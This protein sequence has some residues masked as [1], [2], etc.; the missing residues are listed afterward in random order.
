MSQLK[1]VDRMYLEGLFEMRGGYVLSF[2]NAT[3]ADFVRG[4]TG[5]DIYSE[6]YSGNGGSKANRQAAS[7]LEQRTGRDGRG[8]A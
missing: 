4:S 2:T 8:S 1:P 6:A 5:E 3:F 7:I